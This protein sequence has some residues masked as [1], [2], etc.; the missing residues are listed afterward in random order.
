MRWIGFNTAVS[1]P[2]P[3]TSRQ[4]EAG[5]KFGLLDNTLT[6][7]LAVYSIHRSN[8]PVTVSLGVAALSEQQSKGFEADV[9]WQ[10][11][12]NWSF[13]GSYGFTYAT[14]GSPFN[15][16]NGGTVPAGNRLPFVPASSGRLWANYKFDPDVL[17][18]LS[19]GAGVYAASSQYVD[20]AN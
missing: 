19:I 4:A 2:L 12:R 18:G 5:L 3:E 16:Y 14:F 15:D 13:L 11:T 7:T 20:P 1:K 6:G 8:V 9:I 17:P 10:P